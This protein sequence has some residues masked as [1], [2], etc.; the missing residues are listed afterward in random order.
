MHW[1]GAAVDPDGAYPDPDTWTEVAVPG[2]PAQFAGADA[3][4]Y[5]TTVE[6]PRT[7]LESRAVLDLRGVYAH[8]TVFCNGT[9][10][11]THDTYFEPFRVPLGD[12]LEAENDL[13]VVCR[14]P[15][16]GFGGVYG[17]DLVSD[18]RS[19]PGIWWDATLRT[20]P[21]TY[22]DAMVARP[23]LHG[24]EGRVTLSTTVV[25]DEALDD[26]ITFSVRPKAQRRGRGMM[27]RAPIQAAAGER[28]TVEHS[29]TVRDPALWWPADHGDQH[30]Y[31]VRAKVAGVERTV[32]TGFRSVSR[33][34]GTVLVNGTETTGRGV[35]VVDATEAD[36]E[37]AREVGANLLRT[38]AHVPS[39]AVVSACADAG[40]LLWADLPLSGPESVD[41]DRGR[42]LATALGRQHER[43]PA[44]VAVGVHDDPVD[45]FATPLGDGT[46]DRLRF[47]WR[48]WRADYDG[49]T[50]SS[51]ADTLPASVL[52]FPVVGPPGI[53]A[54]AT[55]LYPGWRYGS[56]AW[57][58]WLLDRYVGTA[59]V[60]EF[61]VGPLPA[62]AAVGDGASEDPGP[63]AA[64]KHLAERLRAERIG[65][66]ATFA[67][68]DPAGTDLGVFDGD[69]E[70][71]PAAAALA[72]AF[73]PVQATLADPT[74]G[75]SDVVV[76]NDLDRR[77]SGTLAWESPADSGEVS[78][79]VGTRA[80]ATV[81][82]I[83]LPEAGERVRLVL[84]LADRTV[85]NDYVIT[86]GYT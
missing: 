49:A 72:G 27:E 29:L 48:T 85:E 15:T 82:E 56:P 33:E 58:D 81:T 7:A 8:A 63:T 54:D 59:A 17:T 47:R 42:E 11:A 83:P 12:H 43:S 51:V 73:E 53:G 70:P 19:V 86:G 24:E 67:L 76:C 45:P 60:A 79:T 6:D 69:G 75:E 61:G 26:R 40:V 77:F 13:R 4:A 84:S 5:R 44:L 71:K 65:L 2:R 52:S 57:L 9:E 3:V 35:N 20:Y 68:R 78:V 80:R 74:P 28:V 18:E 32:T 22:V 38:H 50:A 23:E 36:V 14:R 16:D 37:R 25:A 66:L 41:P 31:V 34:D 55:T 39:P 46:L 30:R 64:L 62:D 1:R 10:L 21:G